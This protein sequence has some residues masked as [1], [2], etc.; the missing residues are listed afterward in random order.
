MPRGRAAFRHCVSFWT[1]VLLLLLLVCPILVLVTAMVLGG[2]LA[3]V[4]GWPFADG[5]FYVLSG[6]TGQP[7]P[8]VPNTPTS[9]WGM[10]VDGLNSIYGFVFSSVIVGLV[11]MLTNV[12]TLNEMSILRNDRWGVALI[13]VIF[14]LSV[15]A[16]CALLG[17]ILALLESWTFE[18]GFYYV[19]SC[20]CGIQ[21]VNIVPLRWH[22]RLSAT[23]IGVLD[24]GLTGV[25]IGMTGGI[26]FL[27][28]FVEWYEKRIHQMQAK[29]C[30]GHEAEVDQVTPVEDQQGSRAEGTSEADDQKEVMPRTAEASFTPIREVDHAP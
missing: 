5:F 8:F 21:L 7:N 17:G 28:Q 12:A 29:C 11:S 2:T 13:L 20:V 26:G 14:P 1:D 23:L 24:M 10:F 22:G 30:M 19:I 6:M 16:L 18:Q 3:G 27:I 25:I 15:L 9:S 4:E